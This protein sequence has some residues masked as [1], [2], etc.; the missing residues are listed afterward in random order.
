MRDPAQILEIYLHPGEFYFGDRDT[1]IRTLL[2]S[3]VA[4][5]AWH[6]RRKIGGM[7]HYLLPTRGSAAANELEGRYA[8]EA[9]EMFRREMEAAG[10]AC[11]EYEIKLFG[12]GDQFPDVERSIEK[13]VAE[14][15]LEAGRA[16]VARNGFKI[17]KEDLGGTGYRN[18][19]FDIDSGDVWVRRVPK[20]PRAAAARRGAAIPR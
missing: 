20:A 15:N 4:I 6:P 10:T 12:G 17:I 3:C 18:L 2:G 11:C 7:C 13:T 1:R 16:L 8:D 14:R 9:V 19:I 5:T